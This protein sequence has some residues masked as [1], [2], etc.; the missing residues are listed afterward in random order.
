MKI[1][2]VH[3]T[4][5]QPGGEDASFRNAR[6]LLQNADHEIVEYLRSNDEVN[7]FVSLRQ[8]TLAKRTIWAGDTRREFREL[9]M[10]EKPDVVHVQNTFVMI[11]PSIYWAC[12]D[13]QVPVVQVMENYRLLCPGALLLRDGKVCEECMVHGV[14]RSVRYG[15]YRQSSKATAVVAAMLATHR[16]LGTWSR[17]I[18]YYLVPTNFGRRKFIEG[19]LPPEKLLVKPNF[20]YPDPGEG[21]GE[22]TY[23]LFVG[24]LSPEKGLRTLLSAWASLRTP[25]PLHIAGDGP[26]KEELEGYVRQNALSCVRFLGNLK[27]DQVMMAMKEARCLLFPGECYEGLPHTVLEAFACGTPVIASSMGAAQEVVLDG[28]VGVQ[29]TPGDTKDLA[30]KTEWAWAHPARLAEMGREARREYEAKYTAARNYEL[31]MKAYQRAIEDHA[32]EPMTLETTLL[33]PAQH[34]GTQ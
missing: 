16:F 28:R 29:F 24:R 2:M 12:R 20:V 22:R 18:D 7:Q 17:L 15:C 13:A 5:Q 19:G 23:A 26:M 30:S 33:N 25:I 3:N 14:W 31:L 8:L 10:R 21:H 32:P 11:S 27:R 1:V 34:L 6:D 9:L 4:Y